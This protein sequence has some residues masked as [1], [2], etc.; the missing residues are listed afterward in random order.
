MVGGTPIAQSR[1]SSFDLDFTQRWV[2]EDDW[3]YTADLSP[4]TRTLNF[5]IPFTI[6]LVFYGIDTIA[7]I[8]NDSSWMSLSCF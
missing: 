8:V 3:T 5:S 4:F 2:V 7:N 1:R 6:L